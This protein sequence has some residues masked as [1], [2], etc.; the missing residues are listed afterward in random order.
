M[1]K[2]A[3]SDLFSLGC[4]MY[5]LCTGRLPFEGESDH[6]RADRPFDDH[7]PPPLALAK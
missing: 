2:C 6:G 7:T 3:G 1:S 5:R 4:V